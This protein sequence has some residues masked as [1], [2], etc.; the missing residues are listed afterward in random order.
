MQ[1][2]GVALLASGV[3]FRRKVW[4]R[5]SGFTLAPTIRVT[6]GPHVGIS[7]TF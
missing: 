5:N 1:V 7:G 3:V 6:N 2:T 4:V